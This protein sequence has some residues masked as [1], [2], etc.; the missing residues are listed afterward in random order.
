MTQW[1]QRGPEVPST[2]AE[3]AEIE[4]D[5]TMRSGGRFAS[6]LKTEASVPRQPAS[7]PWS[8]DPV[9]VEPPLGY[10]IQDM[11]PVG[12]AFEI[13]ESEA[14]AIL[15]ANPGLAE[16]LTTLFQLPGSPTAPVMEGS[17]AVEKVSPASG[18]STSIR[19]PI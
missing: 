1:T 10:S 18:P 13:A 8:N 12:E 3:R 16:R 19:R 14:Q 5:I 9:G 7:S 15:R 17:Q 11:E 2:Y 6:E 4:R